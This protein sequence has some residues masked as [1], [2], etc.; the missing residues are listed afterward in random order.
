MEDRGA[1]SQRLR[2][3]LQQQ[4]ILRAGQNEVTGPVGLVDNALDVREQLRGT[5]TASCSWPTR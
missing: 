5:A 1:P 4:E 2:D 3:G